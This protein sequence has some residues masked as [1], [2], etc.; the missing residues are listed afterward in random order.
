MFLEIKDFSGL[1]TSPR[2][3]EREIKG[4]PPPQNFSLIPPRGSEPSPERGELCYFSEHA[5]VLGSDGASSSVNFSA[6]GDS[7]MRAGEQPGV[8]G[9]APLDPPQMILRGS[10]QGVDSRNGMQRHALVFSNQSEGSSVPILGE[11]VTPSIEAFQDPV[12]SLVPLVNLQNCLPTADFS[13]NMHVGGFPKLSQI[14]LGSI[15]STCGGRNFPIVIEGVEGSNF[16]ANPNFQTPPLQIGKR[17]LSTPSD[18]SILTP[19]RIL[20]PKCL[21]FGEDIQEKSQPVNLFFG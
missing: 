19:K 11:N 20:R 5:A 15:D 16:E 10:P 4:D 7:F 12:F 8:A 13:G 21:D 6:I 2:T 3:D 14:N 17:P 1:K 9:E 18:E